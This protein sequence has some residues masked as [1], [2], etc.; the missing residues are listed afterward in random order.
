MYV[1]LYSYTRGDEFLRQLLTSL[2]GKSG[3]PYTL[4]GVKTIDAKTSI[5]A[6]VSKVQALRALVTSPVALQVA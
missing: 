3:R 1:K 6:M 5:T 2:Y 4:V